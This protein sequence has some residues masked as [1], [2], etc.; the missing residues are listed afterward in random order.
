MNS[1]VNTVWFNLDFRLSGSLLRGQIPS[2]ISEHSTSRLQAKTTIAHRFSLCLTPTD[3]I[4]TQP[5]VGFFFDS[6]IK[7]F[8]SIICT[9]KV[10]FSRKRCIMHSVFHQP[11]KSILSRTRSR[12][13]ANTQSYTLPSNLL[14][15]HTIAIIT[16][17]LTL[18]ILT[19]LGPNCISAV[20]WGGAIVTTK[21]YR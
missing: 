16:N 13:V 15:L 9:R 8:F 19:K 1:Q 11:S 17:Y 7:K 14:T 5:F 2:L 20:V 6:M 18:Q 21:H 12:S 10:F 4:S 3:K